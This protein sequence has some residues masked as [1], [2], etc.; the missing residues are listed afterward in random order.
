VLLR[1]TVRRSYYRHPVHV[2]KFLY[3]AVSAVKFNTVS[4]PEIRD[5]VNNFEAG[6]FA[7]VSE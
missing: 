4:A 2:F 5:I 1:A 7:P 3:T 6:P